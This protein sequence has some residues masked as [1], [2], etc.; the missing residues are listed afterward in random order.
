MKFN[1]FNKIKN[2]KKSDSNKGF[3]ALFSVLIASIVLTIALG[4]ANISLK[5]IV[6]SGSVSEATKSF[7]A[8]DSGIECAL[9]NDL[10]VVPNP[11]I[12]GGSDISCA[13]QTSSV[14]SISPNITTFS[15][16]FVNESGNSCAEVVVDKSNTGGTVVVSS[17]GT[18]FAC[19]TVNPR[20]VE[21]A[22]QIT[23]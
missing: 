17:R 11:F 19:G 6:L 5:Q 21:R 23:Y 18:N 10:K 8:A 4:I 9:Y 20:R 15:I 1:I 16:D 22:I 7:Y 12:S 2:L 3:V 13:G 14:I